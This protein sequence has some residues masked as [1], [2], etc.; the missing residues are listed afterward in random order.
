MVSLFELGVHQDK[1][2]GHTRR[3]AVT[4]VVRYGGVAL[5][6]GLARKSTSKQGKNA[7]YIQSFGGR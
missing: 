2:E 5:E 4:G 1:A 7:M 6:M 3:V